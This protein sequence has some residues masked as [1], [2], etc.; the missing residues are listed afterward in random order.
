MHPRTLRRC[1]HDPLT[2]TALT[3]SSAAY[4]ESSF[5]ICNHV[6]ILLISVMD[7]TRFGSPSFLWTSA[8]SAFLSLTRLSPPHFLM[9]A[10]SHRRSRVWRGCRGMNASAKLDSHGLAMSRMQMTLSR[11]PMARRYRR[12]WSRCA[13]LSSDATQPG[14]PLLQLARQ[15]AK[16]PALTDEHFRVR[17]PLVPRAFRPAPPSVR[18]SQL[19]AG[20]RHTGYTGLGEKGGG[21]NAAGSWSARVEDALV[22]TPIHQKNTPFARPL[23]PHG[24]CWVSRTRNSGRVMH[25]VVVMRSGRP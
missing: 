10:R 21:K 8:A 1:P 25:G 7:F 17:L 19:C 9:A 18:R 20:V 13:T 6:V 16:R 3:S 2:Q 4:W 23:L 24:G 14:R 15:A 12:R 22:S 11:Q 5:N